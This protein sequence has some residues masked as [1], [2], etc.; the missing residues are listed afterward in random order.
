MTASNP[1]SET[2]SI[3]VIV[4]GMR[5]QPWGVTEEQG[6][7][8]Y[9]FVLREKPEQIL[10]LGCGIGT[11]ACYMAA[12][13]AKLG[14]GKIMSIDCN[15]DLPEW[16]ERTFA[17]VPAQ[18]RQY[19]QL[20]LSRTSYND[21]LMNIIDAQTS[22]QGCRP[23]FDF[24]FIDGAHTWEVDGCAFFL[25]EKLLK[26]GKWMLFDDLTWTQALSAEAQ[27]NMGSN[28]PPAEL[29]QTMQ[30]MKVFTLLVAGHPN[31]HDLTIDGDWGW[32][33][34]RDNIGPYRDPITV[35]RASL[36]QRISRKL[37]SK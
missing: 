5:D 7:R 19:H 35:R 27:E 21:E 4:R 37:R 11:S 9:E 34:K 15:P 25:S 18:V 29:Q 23:I 13:L 26:A 6:R 36:V 3:D 10:E 17:K 24:C 31:F 22:P 33:R 2:F 28:P 30:V 32:A 12:A 14:R 8:L 20:I 16:V 1:L